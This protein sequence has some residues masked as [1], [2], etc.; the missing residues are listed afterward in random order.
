MDGGNVSEN[1]TS[2]MG[3]VLRYLKGEQ[4]TGEGPV[5]VK[6]R[7]TDFN[8]A[9]VQGP[10]GQPAAVPANTLI[11]FQAETFREIEAGSDVWEFRTMAQE[12]AAVPGRIMQ[13]YFS[14]ADL[15][16]VRVPS[17]VL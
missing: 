1:K 8:I 9:T 4:N 5:E 3:T 16:M 7:I 2:P 11:S 14:G 15:L 17:K 13:L 6:T 12:G 10:D